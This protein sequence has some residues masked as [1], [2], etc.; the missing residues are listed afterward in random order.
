MRMA[1]AR[2]SRHRGRQRRGLL[3]LVRRG[4]EVERRRRGSRG[5]RAGGSVGQGKR[6]EEQLGEEGG[7]GCDDGQGPAG[8]RGF[9]ASRRHGGG[10]GWAGAGGRLCSGG[11]RTGRGRGSWSYE[12]CNAVLVSSQLVARGGRR[13]R[14]P[15]RRAVWGSPALSSPCWSGEWMPPRWRVRP[16]CPDGDLPSC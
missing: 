16:P 4:R 10:I 11:S 9:A 2:E 6:G 8:A 7:G 13:R 3:L 14:H 1:R 15:G 5:R 12:Q